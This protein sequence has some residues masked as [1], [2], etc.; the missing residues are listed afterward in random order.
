ADQVA[1]EQRTIEAPLGGL[2]EH[3]PRELLLLV[4]VRR[5]RTNDRLGEL[6]SALGEV[7]LCSG[8]GEV[9][10]HECLVPRALRFYPTDESVPVR[11]PT[12]AGAGAGEKPSRP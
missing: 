8:G 11:P 7:V 2:L 4:E 3:R 5:N 9:E 1:V 10:A 6:V 12:A